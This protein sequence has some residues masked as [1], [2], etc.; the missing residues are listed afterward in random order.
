MFLEGQTLIWPYL[1]NGWSNW[2]EMKRKYISRILG[3]L[4]DLDLDN[5]LGVVSLTFHELSKIILRKYTMPEI[6]FTVR[7]SIWN[8][9]H[10]PKPSLWPHV[11]SFSFEFSEEVWFWQFTNV[12]IVSC[13]ARETLVKHNPGADNML[14]LGNLVTHWPLGYFTDVLE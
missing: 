4:C 7:I 14:H 1:R 8:F 11:H 3:I 5:G 12:E 10:V 9:V 2:Y 13:K 6:T